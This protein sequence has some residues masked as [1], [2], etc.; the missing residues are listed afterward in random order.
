MNSVLRQNARFCLVGEVMKDLEK[1]SREHFDGMADNYAATDGE[2]YTPLPKFC[3]ARAAELLEGEDFGRLLDVG[4]GSG[5][6]ISLL[7]EKRGGE[8]VGLDISPAM[9]AHAREKLRSADGVTFAESGAGSLPFGDGAF[10]AVTCIFSFHHYP[11]PE[12]AVAEAYRVLREGGVYILADVNAATAGEPG[13]EEF[14]FYTRDEG[15]ALLERA[16][17]AVEV[18]EEPTPRCFLVKGRKGGA[19]SGQRQP[20]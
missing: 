16:G 14:A 12:R 8:Y 18:A 7:H 11:Y 5:Y 15:A 1:L 17:F 4:C 13:E 19:K 20:R 9:L 10:G 2:Y 6:L 3:C